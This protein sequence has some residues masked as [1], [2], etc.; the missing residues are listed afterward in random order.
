MSA[1]VRVDEL[2]AAS[3]LVAT[4]PGAGARRDSAVPVR[5]AVVVGMRLCVD[6]N[7]LPENIGLPD[8]LVGPDDPFELL[9]LPDDPELPLDVPPPELDEPGD[10]EDPEEEV[11]DPVVV[12]GTA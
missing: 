12:R 6:L 7:S 2:D 5:V 10:A 4:P 3:P 1:L 8:A 11:D 9:E